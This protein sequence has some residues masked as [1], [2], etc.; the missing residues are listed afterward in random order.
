[1]CHSVKMSIYNTRDKNE[2]DLRYRNGT[3]DFLEVWDEA[4]QK[5]VQV[6]GSPE[7]TPPTTLPYYIKGG[8][9]NFAKEGTDLASVLDGS[10]ISFRHGSNEQ[11]I[12]YTSIETSRKRLA[13]I[14]N[15]HIPALE[16]S[17]DQVDDKVTA[18]NVNINSLLAK[19]V[20]MRKDIAFL[21]IGLGTAA[22]YKMNLDANG[23]EVYSGGNTAGPTYPHTKMN[24]NSF[25][26]MTSGSSSVYLDESRIDNIAK[27]VSVTNPS[28]NSSL[29]IIKPLS[30]TGTVIAPNATNKKMVVLDTATKVVN[31]MDIPS[32]GGVVP[33]YIKPTEILMETSSNAM[34]ITPE[35]IQISKYTDG[36]G[37]AVVL[38]FDYLKK[39]EN[40]ISIKK[41]VC[42]GDPGLQAT[43]NYDFLMFKEVDTNNTQL[44]STM[45]Q[46]ANLIMTDNS[47]VVLKCFGMRLN[48]WYGFMVNG[49]DSTKDQ[50]VNLS[51]S[52]TNTASNS[53]IGEVNLITKRVKLFQIAG[54]A[55]GKSYVFF[56]LGN[57]TASSTPYAFN[58]TVHLVCGDT[59]SLPNL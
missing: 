29:D 9:I 52:Q 19:T 1:M 18:A 50:V 26:I 8:E 11:I 45:I 6:T 34:S 53:L 40:G 27:L 24:T 47:R 10:H 13:D 35:L 7:P 5:Y 38:D 22:P 32:G 3:V 20:N 51:V 59:A 43:E 37:E 33:Y 23:L 56:K 55:L 58:I 54:D 42:S 15:I 12:D 48:R 17:V 41:K 16:T 21:N 49:G 2:I 28:F 4:Q 44:E 36:G 30:L 57:T 25:S 14:Q 39:L 31:Y 46:P